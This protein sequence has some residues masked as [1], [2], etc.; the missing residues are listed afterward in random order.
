M[1]IL[2]TGGEGKL[3]NQLKKIDSNHSIYFANKKTLNLTNYNNIESFSKGKY[4]DLIIGNATK[5]SGGIPPDYSSVEAFKITL[6]HS[7]LV[8]SLYKKPKYFINLTTNLNVIDEYF[9]YRAIKTFNEDYYY[10][11]FKI[12]Y[13]DI[14]Y[15]NI[16]PGHIDDKQNRISASNLIYSSIDNI[17]SYSFLNYDFNHFDNTIEKHENKTLR[18]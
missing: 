13:P 5:H 1:K 14:K 9:F 16:H 2:I 7:Y 8:Y 17:D 4:F 3:A 18:W 11:F 6:G 15:F 12:R 10:R